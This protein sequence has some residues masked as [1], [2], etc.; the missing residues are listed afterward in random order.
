M[1]VWTITLLIIITGLTVFGLYIKKGTINTLMED[2]L[3]EQAKKY[4]GLYP[5]AYPTFGNEKK[6]SL[7]ELIDEGYDPELEEGCD[8]YIIVKNEEMGFKYYPF[9]ICP[10]YTTDGYEENK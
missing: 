3:V 5:S 10:N 8:G 1:V 2:A 6:M 7:N 9:V 4:F